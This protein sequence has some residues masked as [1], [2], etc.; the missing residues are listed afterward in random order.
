MEI[1]LVLLIL[2]A[3]VV[4]FV[5]EKFP[6]DLVALLVLGA[7]LLTGL[8]SPDEGISGF[9][10]QATVTVAAMFILS[11]GLQK[12]GGLAAVSGL[13]LKYGRS[14]ATAILLIGTLVGVISAFINN[15]A[16]VAVF[17][18][19]VITLSQKNRIPASKMLIPLSYASQF[20]GVCTLIGTSTNLLVS[21]IAVQNGLAPFSMFEFSRLGL[22]MVIVGTLYLLLFSRWLLPDRGRRE[23]VETF[24]LGEYIAELQVMEGGPLIGKTVLETRLGQEHDVTVLKLIQTDGQVVWVP[25]R[26]PLHAGDVLLVRGK[27]NQIMD[28]K[29]SARLELHAEMKFG[30][31]AFQEEGQRLLQVLVPP[32]SRLT[33]QNLKEID[34]RNRY[35]GLVLA[36]QRRGRPI[37][38]KISDLLLN[39]GDILLLQTNR[40]G[41]QKLRRDDNFLVLNESDYD[42][43]TRKKTPLVLGIIALVIALPALNIIPILVSAILGCLAMVLTRCL[44]MEEAY[45]AIDWKI[46]FLLAGIL[47]LGIAMAKS[48]AAAFLAGQAVNLVG[49]WGPLAVLAVFYLLTALTTETMSNNASAV[50]LAPIAI[51]TALALGVDP[52]PFLMAITFAASTSFATPIGYQTNA[53]VYNAGGYRY[54]DFIKVGLPL[55]LVFWIISIILIP[56]FWP[57]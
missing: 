21:S 18:P 54:T 37:R 14:H 22:V 15:T 8:V 11:A 55:N 3:A 45:E 51:S 28:L 53:M 50:L 1:A 46:I 31:A 27:I 47:P 48:G 42:S 16:A 4:L 36:V 41:A 5:T 6:I 39:A 56:R 10:N 33:G 20:G 9:S 49:G 30:D 40:A 57:F 17:L 12:N 13:L 44:S 23:L 52:K 25:L 24:E 32:A 43:R 7:L 29:E 19:L 34:F 26:Q 35:Q 38:E 2:V